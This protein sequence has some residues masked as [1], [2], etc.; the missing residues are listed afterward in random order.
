MRITSWVSDTRGMPSGERKLRC[1]IVDDNLAFIKVAT[2]LLER[3]G[4]S[5]SVPHRRSLRLAY[6]ELTSCAPTTTPC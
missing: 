2:K 5:L 4:I 6:S 1:V 3:G